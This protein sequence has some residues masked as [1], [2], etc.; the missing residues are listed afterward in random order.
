[1]LALLNQ[2]D[3]LPEAGQAALATI[4][5]NEGNNFVLTSDM[6]TDRAAEVLI[7]HYDTWIAAAFRDGEANLRGLSILLDS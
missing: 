7:R 1:M 5:A 4:Q 3:M 6:F 2:Q